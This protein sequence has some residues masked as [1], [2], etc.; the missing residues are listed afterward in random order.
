M[1]RPPE[2]W[3]ICLSLS[4][5]LLLIT[6]SIAFGQTGTTSVSGVVV[7]ASGATVVDGK[8]VTPDPTL[9]SSH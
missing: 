4:L 9:A 6:A 7:D 3:K 8:P 5:S 1:I 2:P